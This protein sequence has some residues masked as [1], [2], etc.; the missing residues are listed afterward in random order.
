MFFIIK[1]NEY[2]FGIVLVGGRG[3]VDFDVVVVIDEKVVF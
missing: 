1:L 3:V 2:V